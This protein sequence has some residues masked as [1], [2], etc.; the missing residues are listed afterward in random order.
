MSGQLARPQL[1]LLA[2]PKLDATVP[3]FA[4][5]T[6]HVVIPVLIHAHRV[7]VGKAE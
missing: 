3:E 4:Y 1:N 2:K 7:A 6:R 5:G